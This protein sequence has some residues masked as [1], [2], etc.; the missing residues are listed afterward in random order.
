MKCGM[1]DI[2]EGRCCASAS[3]LPKDGKEGIAGQDFNDT[4]E[5]TCTS[6]VEEY[7]NCHKAVG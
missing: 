3:E 7:K 6:Y 4:E 1:C 2:L 5:T